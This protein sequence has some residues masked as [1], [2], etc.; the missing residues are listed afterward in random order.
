MSQKF[1]LAG[2]MGWP[3]AHSRSPLI[4]NHWIA[5]YKLHGAYGHFPVQPNHL[6][7]AIRGLSALGLAGCNITI[8]HKVT[9]MQFV[10]WV[11]PHAQKVGAI[12]TIVVQPDGALHGYNNDGFG[13]IQSIREARPN[14]RASQGPIVVLG[15][16]GASRAILVALIEDGAKEIRLINR[17]IEKAQALA[18]EFGASIQAHP[19]NQRDQALANASLIV[20]TTSL[21][22]HGQPELEIHLDELPTSALVS[23]IVY[24]PLETTLLRNAKLR[25]NPTANGLGMLLHQARP[26]FESWFGILPSVDDELRYKVLT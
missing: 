18:S 26:A 25:G 1:I 5:Q 8:P 17:N 13:Y 6:E 10:N 11:D 22:M 4:H 14:W 3:V 16:G 20:N 15:A 12:N 21:G 23:D 19:W 7:T 9:A 2:V 24:S